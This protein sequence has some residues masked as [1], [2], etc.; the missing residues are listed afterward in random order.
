ML[1]ADDPLTRRMSRVAGGRIA[2]FTLA[3]LTA[4]LQSH[5]QAGGMVAA[6]EAGESG[7]TLVLWDGEQRI[8][9]LHAADIPATLAGWAVFNIQNALAAATAAYALGVAPEDIAAALGSFEGTFEQNPGR[10][11][12]TRVPGFTTIVDYA[13]NPAALRALGN[14]IE[15]L[16]PTHD[17]VIGVVS[18]PG[19]RR[20]EDIFELGRIAAEIFDELVFRERPDGR[21]RAPGGVV[22]ILSDGALAGGARAES[23]HRLMD[24]HQAMGAALAMAGPRDLVVLMPSDVEGVWAQVL[25]HRPPPPPEETLGG[26]EPPPAVPGEQASVGDGPAATVV[27]G[28]VIADD[29][30]S[31]LEPSRG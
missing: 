27:G 16:R 25:A 15:G 11:N 28:Q 9:L 12:L 3:P 13:H 8:P 14:A 19:D 21:G 17:R 18:T 30:E 31:A 24:E 2:Y 20:D 6:L 1:N 23:I 22:S 4:A 10:L 5:L 7:G 29:S 26:L